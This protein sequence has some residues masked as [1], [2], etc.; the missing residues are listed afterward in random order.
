MSRKNNDIDMLCHF[1]HKASRSA[2]RPAPQREGGPWQIGACMK[3]VTGPVR[4]MTIRLKIDYHLHPS[5]SSVAEDGRAPEEAER[6]L[7]HERA[8]GDRHGGNGVLN[9]RAAGRS[10]IPLIEAFPVGARFAP[11]RPGA[12]RPGTS[13]AC[14]RIER[15][16]RF[17]LFSGKRAVP[18]P[19]KPMEGNA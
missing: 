17:A 19:F 13:F 2:T 11:K 6:T 9:R 10:E 16:R 8:G 18:K 5:R 15:L 3:F 14:Y 1:R 7:P 12:F 4:K